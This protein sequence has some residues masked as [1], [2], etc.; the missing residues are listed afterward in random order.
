LEGRLKKKPPNR[1]SA[2]DDIKG[3]ET[4]C[5]QLKRTFE[6]FF[7]LEMSSQNYLMHVYDLPSITVLFKLNAY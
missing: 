1:I 5:D 7:S 3:G 4:Y 6:T 2:L